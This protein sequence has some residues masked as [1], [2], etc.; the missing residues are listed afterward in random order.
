MSGSRPATRRERRAAARA[1]RR[2]IAVTPAGTSRSPALLLTLGALVIGL[3]IV[4]ALMIASGGFGGGSLPPV[5]ASNVAAPPSDLRDGR[6]LG[7]AAAPVH[8]EVWEDPQCPACGV[9]TRQI[10]PILVAEAVRDGRVRLTYRDH[11]F[12][13]PESLD[14][15]VGMR[16]A[17]ALDGRFW[18]FHEIV[19][20]NQH[21]E[22]R[23]AFSRARLADM[24]ALIGLDRDA[25][26]AGLD[27]PAH[28]AAVEA[29][30]RAGAAAGVDSTPTLIING[31]KRTGVPSWTELSAIIDR[32]APA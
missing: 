4:A 14:A 25:F 31:E 9:W 24:A 26:L 30:T 28:R 8:I 22:N 2:Q 10:E 32:L 7:D 29:E 5:A 16:V 21:G 18:D 27:D 17:E 11:V 19:F 15:A 23:G 13:G 20:A 6:S 1:N 3:V 12:L